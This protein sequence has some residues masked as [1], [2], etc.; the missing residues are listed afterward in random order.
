M[1]DHRRRVAVREYS[2]GTPNLQEANMFRNFAALALSGR[3]DHSWG[4]MV[5]KTQEVLNACLQSA[6]SQGP[7]VEMA[8]SSP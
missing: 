7:I 6:A 3:P 1:E 2:N 8:A 4:T 5:L